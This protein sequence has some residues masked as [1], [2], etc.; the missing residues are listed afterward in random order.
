MRMNLGSLP[1]SACTAGTPGANGP[2]RITGYS[3]DAANELTGLTVASGTSAQA[4]YLTATYTPD[5][6][7]ASVRDATNN[8]TSYA[9]DGYDRRVQ[10]TFPLK[11]QGAGASDGTD[12]ETYA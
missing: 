5:G 3:Y 4:T 9:Y 7:L 10:T 8:L 11:T 2:D 12:F 6:Q 1:S